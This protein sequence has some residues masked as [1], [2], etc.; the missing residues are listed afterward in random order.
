MNFVPLVEPARAEPTLKAYRER[1]AELDRI[2][3][4]AGDRR[5]CPGIVD[6]WPT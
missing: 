4:V 3:P 2:I 5:R 1:L 6:G